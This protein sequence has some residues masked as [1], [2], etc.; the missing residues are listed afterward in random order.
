MRPAACLGDFVMCICAC[1]T[2]PCLPGSII[3]A[4]HN[5]L[6]NNRP[7]AR[8]GDI[9]TNCCG[10]CCKCPNN[11]LTGSLKTLIN[12]MPAATFASSVSC[13][14]ILSGSPNTILN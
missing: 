14:V 1:K 7:A 2:G 8:V 4:S 3:T 13:G 12:N 5:T 10:T 9:C 11:I 6:I